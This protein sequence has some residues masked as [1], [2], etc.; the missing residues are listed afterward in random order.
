MTTKATKEEA[1]VFYADLAAKTS[2]DALFAVLRGETPE[3]SPKPPKWLGQIINGVAYAELVKRGHE[4][5]EF[6]KHFRF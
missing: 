2:V 3:G 4:F 5:P 6:E 1:R